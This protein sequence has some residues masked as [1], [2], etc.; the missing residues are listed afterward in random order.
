MY[1]HKYSQVLNSWFFVI[2]CKLTLILY[3]VL[4]RPILIF[5]YIVL[6]RPILIPILHNWT[7]DFRYSE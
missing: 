2:L 6:T 7:S 3:S 1:N 4:T 5:F